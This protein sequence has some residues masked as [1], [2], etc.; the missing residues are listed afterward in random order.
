MLRS[1]SRLS[2]RPRGATS[3][4][5]RSEGGRVPSESCSPVDGMRL[6]GRWRGHKNT[7]ARTT[8]ARLAIPVQVLRRARV[9]DVILVRVEDSLGPEVHAAATRGQSRD[10]VAPD[11]VRPTIP[12]ARSD[13]ETGRGSSRRTRVNRPAARAASTRLASITLPAA[14]ADTAT[15]IAASTRSRASSGARYAITERVAP[16]S[17]RLARSTSTR[18]SMTSGAGPGVRQHA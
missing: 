18:P 10:E 12:V 13:A 7:G 16:I 15:E 4:S 1:P 8:I 11:T 3:V 17:A 5:L 9:P 14:C 6:S 2:Q